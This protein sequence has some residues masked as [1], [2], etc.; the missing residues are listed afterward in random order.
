MVVVRGV[1]SALRHVTRSPGAGGPMMTVLSN[2]TD[3]SR[4]PTGDPPPGPHRRSPEGD[5]ACAATLSGL[6]VPPVYRPV[7]GPS[8]PGRRGLLR[9]LDGRCRRR[10]AGP[11]RQTCWIGFGGPTRRSS[12]AHPLRRPSVSSSTEA[13][14]SD[15]TSYEARESVSR[16]T[17]THR[18]RSIRLCGT[19]PR[20]SS[21][22]STRYS[23]AGPPCR[24]APLEASTS[25]EVVPPISR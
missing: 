13:E 25:C 7:S 20:S 15:A 6:F 3:D 14:A 11:C 24:A 12:L 1:L 2:T 19:R 10:N 18:F 21:S 22:R 9:T 8:Q 4:I 23:V 5:L 16:S 17:R